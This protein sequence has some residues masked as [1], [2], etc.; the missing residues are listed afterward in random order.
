MENSKTLLFEQLVRINQLM[1]DNKDKYLIS[2]QLWKSIASVIDNLSSGARFADNAVSDAAKAIKRA[3]S[4]V[5]EIRAIATFINTLQN[6]ATDATKLDGV[7]DEILANLDDVSEANLKN[8]ETQFKNSVKNQG[9]LTDDMMNSYEVAL[10]RS[11]DTPDQL[12]ILK[13]KIIAKKVTDMRNS[14]KGVESSELAARGAAGNVRNIDFQI[15]AFN[16]IG[17]NKVPPI[18]FDKDSVNKINNLANN[19]EQMYLKG[20]FSFDE[21]SEFLRQ[22]QEIVKSIDEIVSK[23]A[24]LI[25]KITGAVTGTLG[26]AWNGLKKGIITV[27]DPKLIKP[28][29]MLLIFGALGIGIYKIGSM[30]QIALWGIG[31]AKKEIGMEDANCLSSVRGWESLDADEIRSIGK[32]KVDGK[33]LGCENTKN[34][35]DPSVKL[36]LI[37]VINP[38]TADNRTGFKLEFEDG[39]TVMGY[40]G[41]SGGSGGSGKTK[42]QEDGENFINSLNGEGEDLEGYTLKSWTALGDEKYT[43]VLENSSTGGE[44]TY[45][46]KWN[47]SSFESL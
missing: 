19:I 16:S 15:D 5:D 13:N 43:A 34:D 22:N 33:Y 1:G 36:V 7:L 29:I 20:E 46:L 27:F 14:L 4:D 47:G 2:E 12:N 30:D 3:T 28:L 31:K 23:N 44:V 24:T 41:G 35:A 25:E 9:K 6:S 32:I 39:H 37:K 38:T 11:I 10:R 40:P 42:T 26:K 17:R 8:L 45:T 18:K 21:L